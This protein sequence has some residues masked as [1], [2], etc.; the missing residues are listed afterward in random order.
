MRVKLWQGK[1]KTGLFLC[2]IG[3]CCAEEFYTFQGWMDRNTNPLTGKAPPICAFSSFE[4]SKTATRTQLAP[5]V[6]YP[7]LNIRHL[8]VPRIL[9][10]FS[11]EWFL[12]T[13]TIPEKGTSRSTVGPHPFHSDS[14]PLWDTADRRQAPNSMYDSWRDCILVRISSR[15]LMTVTAP[16]NKEEPEKL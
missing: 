16:T 4:L 3:L 11:T 1:K 12:L 5:H 10:M 15:G 13:F 2:Q 6:Y 7:T 8:R 14:Q 9:R